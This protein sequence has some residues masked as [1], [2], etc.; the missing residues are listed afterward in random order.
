MH[1]LFLWDFLNVIAV[2]RD[3]MMKY[4]FAVKIHVEFYGFLRIIEVVE[5]MKV[6][7]RS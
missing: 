3:D 6:S 2:G 4:L 5:T 1:V 7:G